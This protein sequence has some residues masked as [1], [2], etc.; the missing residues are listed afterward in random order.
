MS[1]IITVGLDLAKNVFQVHGADAAGGAV[2]RKKLRRTQVLGFFEALGLFALH[3]HEAH[4]RTLCSFANRLGVGGVILLPFDEGLH[5]GRRDQPDLMSKLANLSTP[6]MCTTTG[7]HRHDA[8]RQS[9]KEPQHLRA[10][11]LLP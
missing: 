1:E 8:R 3:R 2:L 6:V 9:L 10:P 11:Q 4:R 7:F 5:V